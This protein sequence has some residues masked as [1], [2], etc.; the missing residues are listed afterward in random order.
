MLASTVSFVG[1]LFVVATLGYVAAGWPMGDAAYMVLL[2]MF[3]VGFG[4]VH[5]INT[6]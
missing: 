5:P 1:I 4:E 3:S 2:T 6:P